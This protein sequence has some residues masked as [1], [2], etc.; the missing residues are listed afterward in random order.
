MIIG[1]K[2]FFFES[3]PSTNTHTSHLLRIKDLA[4][5]TIVQAGFQSKGKGQM[6]NKWESEDGMNLLISILLFPTIINPSS[7]FYISIM[8]SLGICDFLKRYIPSC[9]IKWP[10]DIY[11]NKNSVMEEKIENSITGIGININQKKF[12]SDAPNPVSLSIL[13]GQKYDLSKCLIQLASD[14]DLRYKQL[15]KEEFSQ[16]KQEYIS[17]IYRLNEWHKYRDNTGIYTGRIMSVTE[18]GRLL[19]EKRSENICEYSFKEVDFIL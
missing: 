19:I 15:L 12:L 2:L 18:N 7:Q 5:G 3:L 8:V 17:Q 6:G 11:I 4:E 14:L 16:L 1:S 13:T 9:S 10:N